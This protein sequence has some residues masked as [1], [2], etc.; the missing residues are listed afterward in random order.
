M[1]IFLITP[2]SDKQL[3]KYKKI[4]VHWNEP[5]EKCHQNNNHQIRDAA[6]G[7]SGFSY[8]S[9]FW[10]R[11]Q[12]RLE[13]NTLHKLCHTPE[14]QPTESMRIIYHRTVWKNITLSI[15]KAAPCYL[16]EDLRQNLKVRINLR[17]LPLPFLQMKSIL[18]CCNL[19]LS[20]SMDRCDH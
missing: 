16:E 7:G 5:T 12:R 15:I 14:G 10:L 8:C 13:L 17:L 3:E 19:Y 9:L 18:S 20:I 11:R 4:T 6:D 1:F 2:I